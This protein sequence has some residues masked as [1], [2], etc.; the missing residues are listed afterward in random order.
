MTKDLPTIT[1]EEKAD[2]LKLQRQLFVMT[3]VWNEFD[4]SIL[5]IGPLFNV[6]NSQT[7]TYR[8]F[9]NHSLKMSINGKEIGGKVDCMLAKGRQIPEIPIFFL[10]E[11]KQESGPS[12]DPLGQLLI[13]MVTA[14]AWNKEEG[15]EI[16]GCYVVGRN[17]FFVVL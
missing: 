5:F 8:A 1:T 17:W 9:F 6:L 12:G 4:R 11:F 14:L 3:D 15:Q 7:L 16:Y 2:L 13:E 10:Q